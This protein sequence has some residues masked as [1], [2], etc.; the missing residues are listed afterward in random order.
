M[1][2]LPA[3]A[4]TVGRA[5]AE[6]ARRAAV[7]HLA[8]GTAPDQWDKLLVLRSRMIGCG[9]EHAEERSS[10]IEVEHAHDFVCRV[11]RQTG[12]GVSG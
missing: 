4:E 1:Q 8:T 9:K 7:S 2:P 12:L 5:F 3:V 10:M 11:H 6:V